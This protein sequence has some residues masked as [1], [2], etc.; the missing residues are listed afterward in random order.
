MKQHIISLAASVA[1][2][3]GA[4]QAC[5]RQAAADIGSSG[6]FILA[7]AGASGGSTS[8]GGNAEPGKLDPR[9]APPNAPEGPRGAGG[10]AA[11]PMTTGTIPTTPPAVDSNN[12]GSGGS[13]SDSGPIDPRRTPPN[14]PAGQ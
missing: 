4:A 11:D 8:G 6:E 2:F 1:L 5:E 13:N 12:S 14:A 9:K 3:A 7:Q 10:T